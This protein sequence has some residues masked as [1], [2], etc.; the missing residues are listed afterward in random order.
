MEVTAYCAC[1][2][3][4]GWHR[5]W[6]GKPVDNITGKR[7][8]VG[9][10]ASGVIARPGT[11]AAPREYPFGT[12]MYVDG[13]GYGRVEDRGGAI[14]GDR[15]DLFFTSH[16]RALAWGRRKVV[17]KIWFPPSDQRR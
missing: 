13:Y 12:V 11:I 6:Y 17:V 14:K 7:K 4:C 9:L 16:G 5:T 2:K 1:G 3:C 15:I 8:R 10:T